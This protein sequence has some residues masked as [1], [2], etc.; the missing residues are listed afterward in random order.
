MGPL[1]SV[2]P[3]LGVIAMALS[4]SHLV[5][6]AVSLVY[7]DGA[8]WA[9]G[10]SLVFNFITGAVVWVSTRR[11]RDDLIARDAILLVVLAWCGGS[12]F[13]TV[14]LLLLLPQ[15]SFT[16]AYF[17]AMSG[18]TTT[19]ASILVSVDQ[20]APS[21]NI[22]RGLLVWLGGMGLIV[23]AVAVLPLLGLG[24]RQI[25][26]AETPGP[27]KESKLTPRIAETAKGL[28]TVYVVI[29]VACTVAYRL[30]GMNW[31]DSVMHMFA[32][33]GLGGFSSHDE[34][35][36]Y[37]NSPTIEAVA[38]VFMV[39][40]SLNFGAHFLAL[41]SRSLAPYRR[42]P[43]A[44]L[45]VLVMLA[46]CVLIAGYLHFNGLYDD[47]AAALRYASFNVVSIASTTGFANTDFN[48]WP[49][50]APFWMLFL[51]SFATCSGS[52]GGGIKMIRA[53]LLYSQVYREFVKLLH[54]NAI[55]PVKV[56]GM[57]VE[58]KI[59][60]AVL[61]FMFIY[62][63]SIV[64]MTLLML[65]AGLDPVTAFTAV[66]ACINNTG[67][68]LNEVGPAKNF[69]GLTDIQTWICTFAMLLGRLE[70]FT[71]FVLFTP[72]FWRK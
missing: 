33:M 30:A 16:D 28:W 56:A 60:F 69:A 72:A 1:L 68:G 59:V 3:H 37:W 50:F 67:P 7:Q 44:R 45:C 29:S 40:A 58:N 65:W 8:H 36:A 43:E 49:A 14:P 24:G 26:K 25:F 53:Q 27:M 63:A 32:T 34:S 70:L 9:F 54:S 41:R 57:V 35:F 13:A 5:P 38:I 4:L 61:A 66:V 55:T 52:T 17:E 47:Y 15:L 12:A 11:R 21:I 42:D 51:S 19:G 18:L 2:A 23:L 62:T 22:W 20:L 46:S 31:F 39:I 6:I 64:S 10:V 48:L 71:V